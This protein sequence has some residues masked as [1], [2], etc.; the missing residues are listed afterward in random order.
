MGYCPMGY[1]P[2]SHDVNHLHSPVEEQKCG[3]AVAQKF[4]DWEGESSGHYW[5]VNPPDIYE[6]S[7]NGRLG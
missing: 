2:H 3:G 7:P 5:G 1:S 4:S 6:L